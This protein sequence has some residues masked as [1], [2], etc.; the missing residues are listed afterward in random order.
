MTTGVVSAATKT[1]AREKELIVEIRKHLSFLATNVS[2][3]PKEQTDPYKKDY[4]ENMKEMIGRIRYFCTHGHWE[5]GY[6]P[7]DVPIGHIHK[8]IGRASCRERV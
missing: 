8:K 3:I 5:E 4:L 6:G 1:A 7:A 2:K